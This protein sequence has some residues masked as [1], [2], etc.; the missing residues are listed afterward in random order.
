MGDCVLVTL[1]L[2]GD[3]GAISSCF[4]AGV[5]E[6]TALIWFADDEEEEELLC[7]TDTEES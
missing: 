1:A 6:C 7:D 3:K 5:K 4:G 2:A